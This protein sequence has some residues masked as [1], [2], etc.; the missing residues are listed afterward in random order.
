MNDPSKMK[1]KNKGKQINKPPQ[2]KKDKGRS[3]FIGSS[4]DEQKLHNARGWEK[5]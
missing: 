2:P 4:R 5:K 3:T 1:R